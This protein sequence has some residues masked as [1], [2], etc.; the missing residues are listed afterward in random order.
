MRQTIDI[1]KLG[2]RIVLVDYP[3]D[4]VSLPIAEILAKELTIQGI[5]RCANVYP[6]AIKAVFRQSHS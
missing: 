2:G 6:A 5:H 4:E 1:V 3:P